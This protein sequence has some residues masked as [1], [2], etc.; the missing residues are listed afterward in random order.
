MSRREHAAHRCGTCHLH[1]VLCVCAEIHPV[2][3]ATRVELLIHYREARKPT[4]TGQLL[5][6]CL[7]NHRVT[8]I[9]RPGERPRITWAD[10]EQPLLLYPSDDAV[11]L[12]VAMARAAPAKRFVLI[13]PDGNWR[14]ASKMRARVPGLTDVPCVTL[15]PG[16]PT[17]YRLRAEPKAEGLATFEAGVRALARLH[18][19][20]PSLHDDLMRIFTVFC[21]RTLW[22]RGRLAADAVTG[23]ISQE[24][25]ALFALS[26]AQRITE[27]ES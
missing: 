12:S 10:N 14:Q 6:T 11:E 16:E 17:Q 27:E 22:T 5:T 21:E 1:R 24:A 23:G 9:G 19:D 8:V 26:R 20:E 13:V 25:K 18:S 4:N 2:T 3:L 7:T 15:P